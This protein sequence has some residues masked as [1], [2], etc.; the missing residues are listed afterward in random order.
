MPGVAGSLL[1]MLE[2]TGCGATLALEQIPRPPGVD[3]DR[4]LIT[5]P[6][7]GYLLTAPPERAQEATEPFTRRGLACRPCGR[8]DDS[9]VL[10]LEAGGETAAVWDLRREPFTH[11]GGGSIDTG[12]PR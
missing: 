2:A 1:Q 8:L 11:L 3:L 9:G 4:W 7:F 6:S 10:R 12:A 5:F